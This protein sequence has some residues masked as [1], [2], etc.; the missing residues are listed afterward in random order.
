MPNLLAIDCPDEF[1][2][3]MAGKENWSVSVG[4]HANRPLEQALTSRLGQCPD[5]LVWNLIVDDCHK[6]NAPQ[7][8]A[9]LSD[10]G[11]PL[12]AIPA[13]Y[14]E[15]CERAHGIRLCSGDAHFSQWES[16]DAQG[17]KTLEFNPTDDPR[18]V[19]LADFVESFESDFE[20]ERLEAT[21]PYKPSDSSLL[22]LDTYGD[23]VVVLEDASV[24][25]WLLLIN[26]DD[27]ATRA[28]AL[29]FLASRTAPKLWGDIF[30]DHLVP[31]IVKQLAEQR[32][33]IILDSRQEIERLEQL[34]Q[35]EQRYFAPYVNLLHIGDHAL[36][37]LVAKT[38]LEPTPVFRTPTLWRDARPE[39]SPGWLHD[40]RQ[41]SASG[42]WS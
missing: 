42:R 8:I 20:S 5:P 25:P 32:D 7:D 38:F 31:R 28:N 17:H 26:V 40:T 19:H 39:R 15:E 35:A 16:M 21:F 12:I 22:Y 6:A 14:I 36:K 23:P 9:K 2:L 1:V 3:R 41:S 33:R 27:R 30:S 4:L 37:D 11:I 13:G 29:E 34:I 24:P 10:A 18:S